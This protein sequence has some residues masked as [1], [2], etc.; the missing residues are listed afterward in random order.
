[1]D[2]EEEPLYSSWITV[3]LQRCFG[4]L[5]LEA[6]VEPLMETPETLGAVVQEAQ[7]VSL[8]EKPVNIWVFTKMVQPTLIANP[9]QGVWVEA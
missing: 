9:Q 1:M 5:P 2:K 6:V 3:V 7:E 4:P 8:W